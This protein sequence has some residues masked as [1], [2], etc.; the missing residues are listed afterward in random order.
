M[1]SSESGKDA[2]EGGSGKDELNSMG[3]GIDSDWTMGAG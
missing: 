1:T 3:V 2:L